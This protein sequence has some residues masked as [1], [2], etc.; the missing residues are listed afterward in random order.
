[1]TLLVTASVT[2]VLAAAGTAS[3]APPGS[4]DTTFGSGG[5]VA[6]GVGTRLFGTTVQSNGKV[7]VAGEAG[8]GSNADVLIARFNASG[9]LD[10][11]FGSGGIVH[12]PAI[13]GSPGSIARA[14]AV[15]SDGKLVVVGSATDS[16]GTYADGL[17]V[18]RYNSS[19]SLDTSFGIGGVVA[20][21]TSSSFG[22]G[23][24]VALQADGKI[25]ATGSASAAGR[26]G[27]APRVAVVRL[28]PNGRLDTGFGVGGID[29]L[30]LGPYSDALA[31]ALQ[32][33]GKVVIAGSGSSGVQ[34]QSALIA[35]L[36]TS[37]AL[38]P[39]FAGTGAYTHQYAQSASGSG[40]NAVAVLTNGKIVAAGSAANGNSAADTLVVRFSPSGAPDSSFG[41]RGVVYTSSAVNWSFGAT[42]ATPGAYGILTAPNG[43]VV[44]AGSYANGVTT[45]A[46]LW[47]LIPNGQLDAGFG[48]SGTSVL[49]NSDGNNTEYAAIAL[50]PTTGNFVAA[51]DATPFGG[52]YTGIAAR[53]FGLGAPPPPPPPPPPPLKLS[54]TGSGGSHKTSAVVRDGL[55]LTFGCSEACTVR[56]SLVMSKATARRLKLAVDGKGPLDLAGGH[57]TLRGPGRASIRLKLS[58]RFIRTLK[59]QKRVSLTLVV[60]ATA[61]AT[62]KV[63]TLDWGVTFRR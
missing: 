15:E 21:L 12:G 18:E 2:I 57:L 25:V 58:K 34:G 51:G 33:D 20:V 49:T 45:Y 16:S 61:T 59:H 52:S 36:T 38:D 63:R 31:V 60:S 50:S 37:G 26:G 27:T 9:A 13:A 5:I 8:A 56:A 46:T 55:K 14:V 1:V 43:D 3:A 22:E 10:R 23:N 62:R 32:T 19:G 41:S 24:A 4:L 17:I 6:T 44:L 40:F 29:V 28:N 42:P 47:A 48:I 11:S 30:D 53:Y 39:G 35:R 54:M 7:V